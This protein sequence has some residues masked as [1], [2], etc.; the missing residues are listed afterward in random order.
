MSEM[1]DIFSEDDRYVIY[2]G[3]NNIAIL[4]LTHNI[5]FPVRLQKSL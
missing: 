3:D 4:V 2:T 5:I 1:L